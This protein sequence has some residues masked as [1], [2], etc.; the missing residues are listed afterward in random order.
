MAKKQKVDDTDLMITRIK[1]EN[2][3]NNIIRKNFNINNEN[4]IRL[5]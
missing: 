5:K 2:T 1:T 4:A 3:Q